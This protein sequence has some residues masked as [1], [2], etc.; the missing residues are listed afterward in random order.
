M[1]K[2]LLCE[3]VW[4]C[5][6]CIVGFWELVGFGYWV[7]EDKKIGVLVGFVGYVEFY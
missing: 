4:V 6:L 1:V 5:M 2:L 7:L 3:E